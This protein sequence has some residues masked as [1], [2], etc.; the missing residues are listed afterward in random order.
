MVSRLIGNGELL[1]CTERSIE[2]IDRK[3]RRKIKD[4]RMSEIYRG[5]KKRKKSEK[6]YSDSQSER[7]SNSNAK[8]LLQQW[9]IIVTNSFIIAQLLT[10]RC[11]LGNV[12]TSKDTTGTTGFSRLLLL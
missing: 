6:R 7:S 8:T 4:V 5:K 12:L 9:W 1:P 11:L 3:E 10:A 2:E